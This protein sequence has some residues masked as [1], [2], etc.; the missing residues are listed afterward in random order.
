MANDEQQASK[1]AEEFASIVEEA[2]SKAGEEGR[3]LSGAEAI[4][5][6]VGEERPSMIYRVLDMKGNYSGNLRL[7]SPTAE[8]MY[9][10]RASAISQAK[11]H[12]NKADAELNSELWLLSMSVVDEEGNRIWTPREVEKLR[13]ADHRTV[14]KLLNAVNTLMG[15]SYAPD[16]TA[17]YDGIQI[18]AID[19]VIAILRGFDTFVPEEG[20][21]QWEDLLGKLGAIIGEQISHTMKETILAV[22]QQFGTSSPPT[23]SDEE[24][25]N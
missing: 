1:P 5:A 22:L 2:K 14:T 25:G 24:L 11:I 21:E 12:P 3:F 15:V 9:R 23:E 13:K 20:K 7:V 4:K 18:R 10:L 19:A 16:M 8:E 17:V 6:L